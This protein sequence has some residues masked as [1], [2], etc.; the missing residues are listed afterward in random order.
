MSK[1]KAILG[2]LA[3]AGMM[4]PPLAAVV[5][6]A[7][8]RDRIEAEFDETADE[9]DLV[10]IFDGVDAR[11][12]ARSFRR[13]RVLTWYGGGDLDLREAAL[14]PSGARLRM[15]SIFGGM[16][17]VVPVSWRVDVRS[18]GIFGGIGKGLDESAADPASPLLV[19]DA[20]SVF[21]GAAITST[22]DDRAE[23]GVEAPA[24]S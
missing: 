3:L 13:G 5:A 4:V 8:L 20:V 16:R 15:I 11:S 23:G 2:V 19:I 18:I 24:E 9:F 1:T 14:D 22:V 21:G 6:R 17:V 7:R 10:A 12:R